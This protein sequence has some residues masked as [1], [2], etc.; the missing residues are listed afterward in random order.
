MRDMNKKDLLFGP[1]IDGVTEADYAQMMPGVLAMAKGMEMCLHQG[2]WILDCHKQEIMCIS[3]HWANFFNVGKEYFNISENVFD[4]IECTDVD[5]HATAMKEIM[6]F[7]ARLPENERL[8]YVSSF[9]L[10]T[11]VGAETIQLHLRLAPIALSHTGKIWLV[12][13]TSFP[14]TRNVKRIVYMQ[15]KGT[16]ARLKLNMR[17]HC[18]EKDLEHLYGTKEKKILTLAVQGLSI[19]EIANVMQMTTDSVKA[20]RRRVF[21]QMRVRSMQ[22]AITYTMNHNFI[23]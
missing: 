3:C 7:Y 16:G 19:D 23:K 2:I 8:D 14:A 10:K 6:N 22:E 15:N 1:A 21:E 18:W 4:S 13:C 9:P 5:F 11:M 12:L 17:T 20:C